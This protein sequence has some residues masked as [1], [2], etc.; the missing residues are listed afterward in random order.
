MSSLPSMNYP[1]LKYYTLEINFSNQIRDRS[2][3]KLVLCG[4]DFI[5]SLCICMETKTT[6]SL[7]DEQIVQVNLLITLSLGSMETYH[8]ISETVL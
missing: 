3:D 6:E 8:V 2:T 7:Q 4:K 5:S 1:A